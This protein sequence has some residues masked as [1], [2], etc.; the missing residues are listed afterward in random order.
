M[1]EEDKIFEKKLQELYTKS[2]KIDDT[3]LEIN[4]YNCSIWMI[5]EK[6]GRVIAQ[7]DMQKCFM[8]GYLLAVEEL[9]KQK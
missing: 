6:G 3:D 7:S 4:A 8:I 1:T 9:N 5:N 2:Y